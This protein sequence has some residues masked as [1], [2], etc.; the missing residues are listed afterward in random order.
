MGSE[1]GPVPSLP[2]PG[3]GPE[4]PLPGPSPRPIPDPPPEPP[5]PGLSPPEGD[6][7]KAPLPPLPGM[8][9][10][11]PGWLERTTPE[12]LPPPLLL[13]G[14]AARPAS[15]APPNPVPRFPLPGPVIEPPAANDGAG[16]TTAVPEPIP[17]A[18]ER[19]P[20][21]APSRTVGGTTK[22]LPKP[23][24]VRCSAE[25][26]NC[27]VGGTICFC[28]WSAPKPGPM[29]VTSRVIVGAGAITLGAGNA[30]VGFSLV[31]CSGAET[32]GG[33]TCTA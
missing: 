7:A 12:V 31:I 6:I 15:S 32:G 23:L 8:P 29:G 9:T 4:N 14:A 25:V 30:S 21:P 18:M 5:S 13:G 26:P 10:F 16:G 22:L 19:C 28:S 3:P 17:P 24:T 11:D 2:A 1:P 33:T 27:T 20:K